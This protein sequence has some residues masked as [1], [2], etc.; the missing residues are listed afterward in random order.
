MERKVTWFDGPEEAEAA[1]RAYYASLT[2]QQRL[3]VMVELC[4]RWGKWNEGRLTR[5]AQIFEVPRNPN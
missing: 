1:D 2:P 4:N 5:V 3:D